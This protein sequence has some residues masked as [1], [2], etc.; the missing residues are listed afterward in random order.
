MH[1]LANT[2]AVFLIVDVS[3]VMALYVHSVVSIAI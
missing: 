2:I 3:V 1:T